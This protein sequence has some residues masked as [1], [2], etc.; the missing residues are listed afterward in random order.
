MYELW[1]DMSSSV[2][3]RTWAHSSRAMQSSTPSSLL[4]SFKPHWGAPWLA[5]GDF[6]LVQ[7]GFACCGSLQLALMLVLTTCK[8]WCM[9]CTY[10]CMYECSWCPSPLASSVPTQMCTGCL[11]WT[12][13]SLMLSGSVVLVFHIPLRLPTSTLLGEI[14]SKLLWAPLH[15]HLLLPR[16]LQPLPEVHLVLLSGAHCVP[17]VSGQQHLQWV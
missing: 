11:V 16:E 13:R 5:V 17:S 3:M 1:M 10:M 14:H 8:W 9:V 2:C 4:V 6:L 7:I 15:L 12:T